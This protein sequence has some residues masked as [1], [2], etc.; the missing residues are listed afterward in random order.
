MNFV[1]HEKKGGLG[2]ITLNRPDKR[3]ALNAVVIDELRAAFTELEVDE[4]V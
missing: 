3:N 1:L 2:I 4:D